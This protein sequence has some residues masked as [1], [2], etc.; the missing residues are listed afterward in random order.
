MIP[1]SYGGT[2][3][4]QVTLCGPCHANVD[5]TSYKIPRI[6]DFDSIE[7][8]LNYIGS[9]CETWRKPISGDVKKACT[10]A[11]YL[12]KLIYRSRLL[13]NK[14]KPQHKKVKFATT[15]S[16]EE[17]RQLKALTKILGVTQ[18]D[19]IHAALKELYLKHCS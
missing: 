13:V 6:D 18:D 12:A 1:R 17:S 15:F 9:L 5:T 14:L 11:Y 3:G 16:G 10:R 19:V 2:N 8:K 4:P 7:S